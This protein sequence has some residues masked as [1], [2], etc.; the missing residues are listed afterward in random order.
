MAETSLGPGLYP[1]GLEAQHLGL[2][3]TVEMDELGSHLSDKLYFR[4][5]QSI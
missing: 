3:T 2:G 1:A 4:R 5:T